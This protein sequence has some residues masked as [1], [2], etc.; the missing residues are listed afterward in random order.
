VHHD[1]GYECGVLVILIGISLLFRGIFGPSHTGCGWW[2]FGG[3]WWP[4][5]FLFDDYLYYD[6]MRSPWLGGWTRKKKKREARIPLPKSPQP[7]VPTP[8]FTDEKLEGLIEDGKLSKAREY[9]AGMIGI[10]KEMGDR[11]TEANY[12][13]YEQK[14]QLASLKSDR[15]K[16]HDETPKAPER[17]IEEKTDKDEPEVTMEF[18]D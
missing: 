6:D 4:F 14:I 5:W 16:R 7:V 18:L 15:Y 9:V 8:G 1:C 3:R 2:L 17:I 13:T 12:K 11:Q 10:A